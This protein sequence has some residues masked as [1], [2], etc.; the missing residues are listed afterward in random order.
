MVHRAILSELL[1]NQVHLYTNYSSKTI[2][3]SLFIREK[4]SVLERT[5]PIVY[6]DEAAILNGSNGG[7]KDSS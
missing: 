5:M 1:I 7:G 3:F 6:H 2:A 4:M